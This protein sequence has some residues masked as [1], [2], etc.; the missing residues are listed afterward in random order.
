MNRFAWLGLLAL[1]AGLASAQGLP[2][3]DPA[4]GTVFPAE[5]ARTLLYQCS[6]IVPQNVE[7]TWTPAAR[8]IRELEARLPEALKRAE[9][10][11]GRET[12]APTHYDRQ[13]GGIVV[14]GRKIVYVNTYPHV[15]ADAHG[16]P[17]GK[18]PR[19]TEAFAVCDG[20]TDFWGAEY[21]PETKTFA[22]F[23]FNG[24]R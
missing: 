16:S 9:S 20:G 18:N 24:P 11:A 21:D 12:K 1:Y 22:H 3:L 4:D 10:A 15:P 7:G 23:S 5:R 19:R 13:Y 14:A 2:G 6:R 17:A 8:Q